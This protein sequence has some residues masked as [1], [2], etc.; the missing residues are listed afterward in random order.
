MLTSQIA[1]S[2]DRHRLDIDPTRKCQID[3]KSMS[4][5]WSLLSGLSSTLSQNT[6]WWNATQNVKIFF[7]KNR[8]ENSVPKMS[9]IVTNVLIRIVYINILRTRK[10]NDII[11]WPCK[12]AGNVGIEILVIGFQ[13]KIKSLSPQSVY[14]C[15]KNA[16]HKNNVDTEVPHFGPLTL[17]N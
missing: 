10:C 15:R 3:V 5:W 8:Y 11:F 14:S 6:F 1:K 2:S 9:V 17:D 7:L 4:I 16:P 12:N 13:W